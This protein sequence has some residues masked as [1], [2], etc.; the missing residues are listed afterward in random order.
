MNMSKAISV[1]KTQLGLYELTLPFKDD[2]TG[3]TIPVEN[4]IHEVLSTVTISEYSQF[5][6]WKRTGLAHL[7]SL[8]VIDKKYDIYKLPNFL[9][10][11]PVMWVINVMPPYLNSR[12]IY[13]DIAPVG[14]ISRSVGGVL[15][16]QAYMMVA[17]EMRSEPTFNY[18]GHN[19]IQLQGYPKAILEFKLACE[20]EPNGETIKPSCYDSFMQLALLDVKMFLYSTLK[21]Y[22]DIPTAF[23]NINLKIDDLQSAEEARN[24]LLEEWRNSS[25]L[26]ID[27]I[28]F[29]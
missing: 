2:I 10:L 1:I 18:L 14:G 8:E 29:M 19:Q 13:N 27:H 22:N 5:M 9:T 3:E 4:V 12:G 23:G 26:D 17:G 11:T 7:G 28:H 15:T 16:S 24:Q 21:H 6:P 20:H 25:N